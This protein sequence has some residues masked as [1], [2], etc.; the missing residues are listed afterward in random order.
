MHII[1]HTNYN[2]VNINKVRHQV[3]P[4]RL[5]RA[6]VMAYRTTTT[7][8]PEPKTFTLWVLSMI[9][10]IYFLRR[11]V[12]LQVLLVVLFI[13]LRDKCY[14][15]PSKKHM[16]RYVWSE[17]FMLLCPRIT[18]RGGSAFTDYGHSEF[19]YLPKKKKQNLIV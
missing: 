13:L 18:W 6:K 19:C 3:L 16:K 5:I 12:F 17:R 15:T 7:C 1:Y 9:P 10:I 2:T 4:N 8:F 11:L 14:G